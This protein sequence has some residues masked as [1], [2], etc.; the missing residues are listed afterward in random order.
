MSLVVDSY[1]LAAA[2]SYNPL[3]SIS[4]YAAWWAE[5][6]D[7]TPPADGG[8]VSSWRNAGTNGV[9]ATQGTG[10]KQPLYRASVASLNNRPAVDFDGSNDTLSSSFGETLSQPLTRVV[11]GVLDVVIGNAHLFSADADPRADLYLTPGEAWRMWAGSSEGSFGAPAANTTGFI[12][13]AEYN[14]ASSKGGLN[15]ASLTTTATNPG[16][17]GL[18]ATYLASWNDGQFSN[19]HLAFAG[20]YAGVLSASD[21]DD[22]VAW[23]QSHY[24]TP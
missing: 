19:C 9:A 15:T 24:G 6:P 14:G 2:P 20:I 13:M 21:K 1:R 17:G 16:T 22:L 4:W 3:T 11:V 8:A 18:D 5:D 10:I 12:I 7:W 23:S